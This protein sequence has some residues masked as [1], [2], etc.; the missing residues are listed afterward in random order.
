MKPFWVPH[1]DRYYLVNPDLFVAKVHTVGQFTIA[2]D[3]NMPADRV[4]M[5]DGAGK[6]VAVITDVDLRGD[7]ASRADD[8]PTDRA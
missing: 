5:I 7:P 8:A 6:R 2:V 1:G 4:D 3:P